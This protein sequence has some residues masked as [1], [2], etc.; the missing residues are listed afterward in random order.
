MK[1]LTSP[2]SS[3]RIERFVHAET[4]GAGR[5]G[6]SDGHIRLSQPSRHTRWSCDNAPYHVDRGP[7]HQQPHPPLR[8]RLRRRL[9]PGYGRRRHLR[10][11]APPTSSYSDR[12]ARITDPHNNQWSISTHIEDLTP[13]QIAERLVPFPLE[14][15]LYRIPVSPCPSFPLAQESGVGGDFPVSTRPSGNGTK[16]KPRWDVH[17]SSYDDQLGC[18]GESL[19]SVL[20]E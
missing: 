16:L 10:R 11:R 7:A 13:D 4:S 2:I 15:A 6:S 17:L 18:A 3:R 9:R 20:G 8:P 14:Y 1:C 19:S 12:L 5:P